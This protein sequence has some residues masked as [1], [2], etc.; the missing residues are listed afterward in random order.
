MNQTVTSRDAARDGEYLFSTLATSATG[1]P[2]DLGSETRPGKSLFSKFGTALLPFAAVAA[3]GAPA[4]EGQVRATFSRASRSESVLYA[5]AWTYDAWTY[6]EEPADLEQ[7]HM[8]N[9]L[10][11]LSAPDGFSLDVPD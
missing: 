4:Y 5:I 9:Q 8:L 10:L 3:F 6:Y 7:I 2:A 1:V 11:S